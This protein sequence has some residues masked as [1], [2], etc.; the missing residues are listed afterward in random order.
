MIV[1]VLRK[2]FRSENEN[3]FEPKLG[4]IEA[5]RSQI[6]RMEGPSSVLAVIEQEMRSRSESAKISADQRSKKIINV[7][8][9]RR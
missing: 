1:F 7:R 4:A 5:R 2:I 3:D 8:P 9:H 6:V